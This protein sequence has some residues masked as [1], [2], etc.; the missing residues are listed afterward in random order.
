MNSKCGRAICL[1]ASIIF[2]STNRSV[3]ACTDF[4]VKT[5]D[6]SAVVG[7]SMEWSEDMKSHICVHPRGEQRVSMLTNG[8]SGIKWRSSYGIVAANCYGLDMAVDGMN[9]KGLSFAA[10]WFPGATYQ[11]VESG[12]E[13]ATI[14]VIDLGIWILGNCTTVE[15]AK[16]AISKVRVCVQERAEIGIV[17]MV[18]VALHDP[19]GNNAVIEFVDG[20][21][22]VYDNRNGVLTNAPT[23]DWHMTNLRNYI[24]LSAVNPQPVVLAGSVLA[25]PGQG[26][27]LLGIPGDWTPPSR[28]VRTTTMLA[29]AKP[30]ASAAEGVNLAQHVLNAVDIPLGDIRDKAGSDSHNDYT[31]W[32]VVKDLSNK[33]FYFRSYNDQTLRCLDLKRMSFVE[34]AKANAIPMSGCCKAEDMTERTRL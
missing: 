27:G 18:H 3:F 16:Q 21:V 23:F 15:E 25:P 26:S 31:Q 5:I 30:V 19:L 20:K 24:Q 28:F 12:Q 11:S 7:R 4:V 14:D 34:N 6:G 10:L 8:K 13:Q 9:E 1:L 17:P 32:A 33:V 22:R 29:Y 2:A